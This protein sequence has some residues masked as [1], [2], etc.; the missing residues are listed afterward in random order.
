MKILHVLDHYKPHFSGYVF[1]TSYILKYQREFGLEP[2][3]VTSPKHGEAEYLVETID[4]TIVYRTVNNSFGSVPFLKELRLIRA[5]QRKIEQVVRIEKP[6]IIH[7][8]SPSLNGIPSLIAA[9]KFNIPVVYEV[10]AFWEDAAIDHGSF[11]DGSFM[12]RISKFIETVL[13]KRVDAIFTICEGLRGEMISR[14]ISQEKI[15]VIQN[16]VDTDIFSRQQYDEELAGKYG[17]KGELVFGFIGS[18]YHYEGLD[19]LIDSFAKAFRDNR[20]MKLLLVGSGP[21]RN[22]LHRKVERLGMTDHVVFTG[23]V[24]HEQVTRYYSLIDVLIYPRE[25]MRLTECVTP[26][27]PLEAMAMGKVVIGSSVG[28]IKELITHN[29]NGLLFEAG[30]IDSLCTLIIELNKYN[31]VFNEI[32]E[33]AEETVRKKFMWHSAVRKYLPVYTGLTNNRIRMDN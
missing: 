13:L 17:L 10:R 21:E 26:L 27:K 14:G 22:H 20:N 8:H 30:N 16:C 31:K 28:G 3:I 33:N 1:R 15:T 9:R 11:K 19:I 25:K 12:Y 6:D 18:F 23:S 5:L 32:A 7:A 29:Q 2:V 4:K 24:P